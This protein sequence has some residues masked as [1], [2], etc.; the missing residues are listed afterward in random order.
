MEHIGLQLKDIFLN[1]K[2][3]QLYFQSGNVRKHMYFKNGE[4]VFARTNVP[5]ELIGEV[6][7]RLGKISNEVYNKIDEYIIP[8]RSIGEVMIEHDL[9]SKDDL[10]EGLKYQLREVTLNIFASFDGEFKFR[11]ADQ[12]SEDTFD[13]AIPIPDLIEQGVRRM[14]YAPQLQ[15]YLQ[16]AVPALKDRTFFLNLTEE[17]KEIY[18]AIDGTSTAQDIFDARKFGES[19]FWKAMYLF[20]CLNLI[21]LSGETGTVKTEK[22]EAPSAEPEQEIEDDK[23]RE[24]M[25]MY[26]KLTSM[27]YYHILDV[28]KEATASEVKKAYFQMARKYHPDLFNRELPAAVRNR[29]D[30]VFDF[31]TKGYHVLSDEEK[32]KDYDKKLEKA[33]I[34][35]RKDAD[36]RAEVKFRQGKTLYDQTRW[37]EA[38]ILLQEAIR[39]DPYKSN[40]FLLLAMTQSK[41]RDFHK[42]A[43]QN[44]QKAIEL[45][46]WQPDGYLGLGILYKREGMKI[47]AAKYLKKALQCDPDHT[48]TIKELEDLEEKPKKKGFKNVL[49]MDTEDL[50]G[51]FKKDLFRKK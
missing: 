42:K 31:I 32:R 46:P 5:Q 20:F 27:S 29:I 25:A 10:N 15:Q 12:F 9:I 16:K 39:L 43:V 21:E 11:E 34:Q 33:P 24:V 35:D 3:G 49:S 13:V 48:A 6:L 36:K 44:F 23:V 8:R 40:Y 37:E 4:L 18:K 41:M 19:P 1:K 45:S 47:K 30:E 26:E 38:Q 28:G 17:E 14:K 51:L 2:Q 22:E 50:K 7:F